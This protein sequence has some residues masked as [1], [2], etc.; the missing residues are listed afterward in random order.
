M[1]CIMAI[2]YVALKAATSLALA[3]YLK[4]NFKLTTS[5]VKS[6]DPTNWRSTGLGLFH[7]QKG[8]HR[9]G[10]V[11]T[12]L[13][14][15][16]EVESDADQQAKLLSLLIALITFRNGTTLRQKIKSQLL[17]TAGFSDIHE[18]VKTDNEKDMDRAIYAGEGMGGIFYRI[19]EQVLKAV[20]KRLEASLPSDKDER[21]VYQ[22]KLS[23][24]AKAGA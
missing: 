16:N 12:A 7:G 19:E 3:N 4:E 6:E 24:S 20:I 8:L 14:E 15:L 21:Q 22:T 2:D 9:A 13:N 17:E 18:K 11:Y 1:R 23:G 10:V 5:D